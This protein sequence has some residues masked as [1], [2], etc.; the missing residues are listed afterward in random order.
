MMREWAKCQVKLRAGN[1]LILCGFLSVVGLGIWIAD[2]DAAVLAWPSSFAHLSHRP[3]LA[4]RQVGDKPLHCKSI[5][6]I[7][8]MLLIMDRHQSP[9]TLASCQAKCPVICFLN[10]RATDFSE[11]LRALTHLRREP[12]FSEVALIPLI[13]Q[14]GS[15]APPKALSDGSVGTPVFYDVG[16]AAEQHFHI[17]RTP[18]VLVFNELWQM[19]YDGRTSQGKIPWEDLRPAIRAVVGPSRGTTTATVVSGSRHSE[20]RHVQ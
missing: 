12:G 19:A 8:R 16:W 9:F 10:P 6:P 1:T 13:P 3:R 5:N 17:R 18:T 2:P 15:S 4:A 14:G 11:N 7:A 20:R